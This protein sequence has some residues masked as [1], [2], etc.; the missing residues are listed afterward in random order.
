MKLWDII[1]G[2]GSA[3]ITT[4]V[5][6]GGLLL[7]AI[8]AALPDDK[9]I[10]TT[11]T[12]DEV[13]SVIESL[14]ADQRAALMDKE[15]DVTLTQIKE[16]NETLRTM[17]ETEANSPQSTRPYIA[18]GAFHVVAFAIIVVVSVWAY[19]VLR[20]DDG[21]V[22]TVVEGWP[23]FL[24]VLGPL[25]ALLRSYFGVVKQELKNKLDAATNG[26]STP[27]GITGILSSLI[28]RK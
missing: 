10:P 2:V 17:L 14:P 27:S 11:A 18:K 23:W 13:K 3:A 25:V 21:M 22:K 19:A 6:G 16:S 4:M 9:Q 26:G 5:P 1:K 8:N 12:G 28:N 20:S 7:G 24:A 15:F